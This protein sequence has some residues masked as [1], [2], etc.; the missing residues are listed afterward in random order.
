M[1]PLCRGSDAILGADSATR[2]SLWPRV[3]CALPG[4]YGR[5]RSVSLCVSGGNTSNPEFLWRIFPKQTALACCQCVLN[6]AFL[7]NYVCARVAL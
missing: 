4:R 1:L 5:A 3:D 6:D 7:F 2:L